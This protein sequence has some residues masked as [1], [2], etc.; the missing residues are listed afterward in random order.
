MAPSHRPTSSS[1]QEMRCTCTAWGC[2]WSSSSVISSQTMSSWMTSRRAKCRHSKLHLHQGLLEYQSKLVRYL[3]VS[4]VWSIRLSWWLI[5][6]EC[7][8]LLL[9][10]AWR[11]VHQNIASAQNLLEGP[12]N[13]HELWIVIGCLH[14]LPCVWELCVLWVQTPLVGCCH[15]LSFVCIG[16]TCRHHLVRHPGLLTGGLVGRSPPSSEIKWELFKAFQVMPCMG[17]SFVVST[18]QRYMPEGTT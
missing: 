2:S 12:D 16:Y 18:K 9:L 13:K 14:W 8:A 15:V 6:A 3:L 11:A 4:G 7:C 1:S 5:T 10:C 17:P